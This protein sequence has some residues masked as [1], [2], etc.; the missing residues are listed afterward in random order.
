M[1]SDCGPAFGSAQG[2]RA[3]SQARLPAMGLHRSWTGHTCV[4]K[5]E[6]HTSW[7]GNVAR[8]EGAGPGISSVR[9]LPTSNPANGAAEGAA[10]RLSDG[11]HAA[12]ALGAQMRMAGPL[13]LSRSGGLRHR[14]R[15]RHAG[16][17]PRL[18]PLVPS[19]IAAG[20]TAI[21]GRK[22]AAWTEFVM[23]SRVTSWTRKIS[24]GPCHKID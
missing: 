11:D 10:D 18:G 9:T 13:R 5:N 12:Q 21:E 17:A 8:M 1:P 20:I 4:T 24:P 16:C 23:A 6:A 3:R 22:R 2:P 7:Q 14:L 15:A 19:P